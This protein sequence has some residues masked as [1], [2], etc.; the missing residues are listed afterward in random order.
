M[1]RIIMENGGVDM[2]QLL[3][4]AE[5]GRQTGDIFRQYLKSKE[6]ELLQGEQPQIGGGG[7][8]QGGNAHQLKRMNTA[9][10]AGGGASS[11]A[12]GGK[13]A[14]QVKKVKEQQYNLSKTALSKRC[15]EL[16]RS[17][18]D[19]EKKYENMRHKFESTN[20]EKELYKRQ[21]ENFKQK[22]KIQEIQDVKNSKYSQQ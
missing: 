3:Q 11:N 19:D 1:I 20:Q 8:L 16:E 4:G 21:V 6:N 17:K 7:Q 22:L 2:E 14:E 15:A 12:G 10:L 13:A 9:N 5:G 18:R